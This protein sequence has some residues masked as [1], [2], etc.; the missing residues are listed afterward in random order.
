[1]ASTE[2]GK[3]AGTFKLVT[4]NASAERA[5]KLCGRICEEMRP[6]Y[7]IEH[8]A[9]TTSKLMNPRRLALDLLKN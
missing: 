4:V 3:P 1:M 9:N 7:N 8:V 6:M 2:T 5:K